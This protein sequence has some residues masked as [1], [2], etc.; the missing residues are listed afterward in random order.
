MRTVRNFIKLA[1]ATTVVT[2]S[3]LIMGVGSAWL[4]FETHILVWLAG[5]I[6][7]FAAASGITE[8]VKIILVGEWEY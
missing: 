7:L 2:I 1:V 6:I 8:L 3:V 5:T 4:L